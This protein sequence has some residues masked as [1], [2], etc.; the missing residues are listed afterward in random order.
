MAISYIAFK[1]S[2]MGRANGGLILGC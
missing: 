2:L 1:A